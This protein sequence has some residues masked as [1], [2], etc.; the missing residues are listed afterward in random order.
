MKTNFRQE[1]TSGKRSSNG[2]VLPNKI[3]RYLANNEEFLSL[4]DLGLLLIRSRAVV[5][6]LQQI[7]MRR[8]SGSSDVIQGDRI[9]KLYELGM[10]MIT[11]MK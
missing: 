8:I 2:K 11:Q 3:F 6:T 7:R 10:F 9:E 4:L 1:C 5:A